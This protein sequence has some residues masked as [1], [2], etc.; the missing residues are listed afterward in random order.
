MAPSIDQLRAEVETCLAEAAGSPATVHQ[1]R[2]IAGG[3]SRE[4]W[5][6]QAEIAAGPQAGQYA[7]VMRRDMATTM[8]ADAIG[9]ADEF[10][11]LEAAYRAG[12]RVPRPRW[13]C[14]SAAQP[15]FLMDHVAGESIGRRVVREAALAEAR[16]RLPEQIAEQLA[17][18]HAMDPATDAL[19][20]LPRPPEGCPPAVHIA[21][22]L[23]EALEALG[24]DEPVFEFACRWLAGKA[25]PCERL[26]VLHGD[27][28]VGNVIVGP[29]GLRAVID[30]EFAHL[31]DPW[32]DVA[33]ACVRDWRFGADDLPV[34]GVG[35]REPYLEAYA[36]A[37]GRAIDARAV[38]Y[39]EIM[40]NLKWGVT[41]L[42][43][44][45]RHL[46]G[47]DPSVEFAS[48]GRRSAEMQWE[49]VDL[50]EAELSR[51]A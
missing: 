35:E 40:G 10:H 11:L 19:G 23:R 24:I 46:S 27:L 29:D 20:F 6:I 28:R 44:A 37:S 5:A 13:L 12:V 17:L 32:E 43:Q 30:W 45:Q 1:M 51:A 3:A 42:V 49:L 50:I 25:P 14:A 31:G 8:N 33:W 41:C 22:R 4:T 15:F 18:I 36:R 34:G 16:R 21:N 9:R 7:L 48:L 47:A 26:C 2:P 38:R 39:W